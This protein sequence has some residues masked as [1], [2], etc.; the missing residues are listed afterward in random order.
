[1]FVLLNDRC[2]CEDSDDHAERYQMYPR[3]LI[4]KFVKFGLPIALLNGIEF[5]DSKVV[6]MSDILLNFSLCVFVRS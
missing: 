3:H 6:Y 2:R 4:F 1:M 5:H